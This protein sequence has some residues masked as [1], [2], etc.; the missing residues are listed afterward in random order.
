MFESKNKI[1]VFMLTRGTSAPDQIKFFHYIDS[2]K[3]DLPYP[4]SQSNYNIGE[5]GKYLHGEKIFWS[6]DDVPLP[7]RRS[8]LENRVTGN[9]PTT[10]RYA[11][12]C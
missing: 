4:V 3:S 1:L 10:S 7:E 2:L 6:G 11:Y 9:P 12:G 5:M 8:K